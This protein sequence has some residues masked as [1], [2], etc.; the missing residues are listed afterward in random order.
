V[1]GFAEWQIKPAVAAGLEA[2]GWRDDESSV[3]DVIPV[4]A[5]GS[6][7]V[8]VLPPNPAWADPLVAALLGG[9][10][11]PAGPVLVLATPAAVSEWA[12]AIGAVTEPDPIRIEVARDVRGPRAVSDN[13]PIDVLIASPATALDR[14]ARSAL[15]PERFRAVVFAWPEEWQADEAVTAL[16]QDFPRDAQRIVLTVRADSIDG[17]GGV[18]ERYA[19]KA[20]VVAGAN[21]GPAGSRP[22]A[23]DTSV[24]TV[25]TSWAARGLTVARVI[26]EIDPPSVTIWTADRRDHQLIQRALGSLR[27]GIRLVTRMV[28]EAG[29][30]IC[31][32]L[33]SPT[34]LEQLTAVG[35][36]VLLVAPGTE[37]YVRGLAPRRRPMQLDSPAAAV[38]DRDAGLR[39]QIAGALEH[40]DPTAALYAL[41]PLFEQSDPQLVAAAVFGLWRAAAAMG[42][43]PTLT[44]RGPG[45][46]TAAAPA[47]SPRTANPGSGIA[48][49]WIG[50]GKK[51]E[52]TVGDF[53]AVLIKEA[54]MERARIGRIELRDTFALVEVP[55][56]DAEGIAQRLVGLTIRKRKLSARVDRG[57]GGG[58]S[59]DRG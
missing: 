50:A 21:D 38:L 17:S 30:V 51:D 22:P 34:Q 23:R 28:P 39:A 9:Q 1:P 24:R 35:E 15:H 59:R 46:A 10:S 16:L 18:V 6:N 25:P 56:E 55:A 8:I 19:R 14:H 41:S 4:V 7:V 26:G 37:A 13:R 31:Y 49:L 47:D 3:R 42:G 27:D 58:R 36:V 20:M 43:T 32:D 29:M 12:I 33:P 54:G 5:R 2:L 11:V 44:A 48:K 40:A 45:P 57:K 52:A 53:V